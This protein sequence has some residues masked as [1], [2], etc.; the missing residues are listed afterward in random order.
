MGQAGRT[1]S[2]KLH[3]LENAH[4]TMGIGH[5]SSKYHLPDVQGS[6][7][8]SK[9]VGTGLTNSM[10]LICVLVGQGEISTTNMMLDVS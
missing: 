9:F 5:G 2:D 8:Q 7:T 10:G 6:D 3:W 1:A 4:R